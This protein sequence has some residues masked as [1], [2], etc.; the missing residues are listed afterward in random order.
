MKNYEESREQEVS[1]SRDDARML[2]N[3]A[4]RW[5]EG[6]DNLPDCQHVMKLHSK[7]QLW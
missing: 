4:L 2:T 7:H 5:C 1:M 6:K 3:F